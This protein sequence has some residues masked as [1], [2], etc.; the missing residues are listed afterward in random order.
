[1][2]NAATATVGGR[3]LAGYRREAPMPC[4][5][6]FSLC[7]SQEA[8]YR[9]RHPEGAWYGDTFGFPMRLYWAGP[10]KRPTPDWSRWYAGAPLAA[11]AKV[12]GWGVG[13]ESGSGAAHHMTRMRHP[14]AGIASAGE[15][16]AY[17]WP[18]Y[19]KA[20]EAPLL[21]FV[22]DCRQRGIASIGSMTCTIWETS[23]F[24]RSMERLM[25]DMV[26]DSPIAH[27]IFDT[28]TALACTRAVRY[29]RLGF[30]IL[31]LGDDIGTQR[32]AM[33]SPAMWRRWL[34]PRLAT[35]IA[36]ARSVNPR[37]L[38][39]YHSCGNVLAF[40]DGLIE[41]GVDILNPVQPECMPVAEVLSRWGGRISFNGVLGTQ[42]TLPF[43]K[44]EEVKAAVRQYRRIAGPLGG[45]FCCPTHIV[46][47]EVPWDNLVAYAEASREPWES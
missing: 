22:E 11:G 25:E 15:L 16:D 24:L 12:D 13:H 17:P 37:I 30:D 38:V 36:A 19:E 4:A 43:G 8:E 41:T 35:V 39:Q 27:R 26:D 46:E 14:L 7:A 10:A 3:I 42:S 21:A 45:L 1:M 23:W 34:K 20:D 2:P 32:G 28:V 6:W 5:P 18:D 31:E 33:M 47:P 44:P 29:A 9:R 40:I